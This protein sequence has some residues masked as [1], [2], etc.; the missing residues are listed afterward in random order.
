MKI[1]CVLIVAMLL[2]GAVQCAA[3]QEGPDKAA[4]KSFRVHGRLSVYNGSPSCRIWIVGTKRILGIHEAEKECP[5]PA[6]LSQ[7]LEENLN[8]RTVY[9]DFTVV[10][11]TK[12]REG[13]M[14]IVT[15]KSAEN[16][17]VAARDGRFLK[18]IGGVIEGKDAEPA[19]APD[20][21]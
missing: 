17:V 13:V 12:A 14:Q 11:L 20:R 2:F 18:R 3:A 19:G 8:D 10:P 1:K 16:T 9:A 4:T 7:V 6:P 5:I 21:R 15:L